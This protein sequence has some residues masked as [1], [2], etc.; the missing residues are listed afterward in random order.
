MDNKR[1]AKKL[2][3]L[4]KKWLDH[5]WMG[6]WDVDMHTV[7]SFDGR[8]EDD[9]HIGESDFGPMT[10]AQVVYSSPYRLA[11]IE[12][13]DKTLADMCKD[14]EWARVERIA[15][16]EAAHLLIAQADTFV[17]HLIELL[18]GKQQRSLMTANWRDVKESTTEHITQAAL[19][20][21]RL[22]QK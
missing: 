13:H 8:D 2:F 6:H 12:F 15:C 1:H 10:A 17:G 9:K 7:D 18:P 4:T 16:H 11:T 14:G 19:R 20:L 22:A 5:F 21:D 3:G